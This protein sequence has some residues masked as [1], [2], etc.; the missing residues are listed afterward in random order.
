MVTLLPTRLQ[1]EVVEVGDVAL[2]VLPTPNILIEALYRHRLF[3]A[4]V[5]GSLQKLPQAELGLREVG[6]HR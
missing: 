3:V 5:V 2:P 6:F 1:D 4:P